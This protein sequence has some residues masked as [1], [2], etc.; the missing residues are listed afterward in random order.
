MLFIEVGVT[1]T[2]EKVDEAHLNCVLTRE[3]RDCDAL[4]V[5]IEDYFSTVGGAGIDLKDGSQV[6]LVSVSAVDRRH[7]FEKSLSRPNISLVGA[8][9]VILR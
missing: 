1:S 3:Y 2:G 5:L 4:V 6:L 7:I 9:H 8:P